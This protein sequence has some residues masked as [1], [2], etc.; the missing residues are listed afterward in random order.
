V[1]GTNSC[2]NG[3]ISPAFA[4]T[5][6]PVPAAAVITASGFT[7]TSSASAGNQW[8]FNGNPIPGAVNQTYTAS[9]TGSYWSVVSLLGCSS[10]TSNHIY[11]VMTGTGNLSSVNEFN[12]YPNPNDGRFTVNMKGVQ[13]GI[14]SIEVLNNIGVSIWD[15]RDISIIGNYDQVIDLGPIPDGIYTVLVRDGKERFI[16]K[17]MI[18]N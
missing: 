12:V 16:R 3:T 13:S 1:I 4:L 17:V 6:N 10:D 18:R 5:V 14:Y 8:Y 9:V 7:L 2:G 11:L 15:R